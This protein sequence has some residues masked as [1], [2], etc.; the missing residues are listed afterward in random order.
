[1]R[2]RVWI[3]ALIIS[4]AGALAARADRAKQVE[5]VQQAAEVFNEV[6]GIPEKS[7]P[8]E[9][10]SRA[11]CVAIIPSMK[12]AAFGVG[13]NYGRGIVTCRNVSR[14]FGSPSMLTIGG[15][16]FGLQLGGQAIDVIM[17]VMNKKGKNF[18][19]KDKFTVGGDASASAGPVG[20]TASAETNAAMRAEILTYSRS[21]GLFA[22]ISLKG[23]VVK[24]DNDGN[25]ELYGREIPATSILDGAAPTPAEARPLVSS[26]SRY[27]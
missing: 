24:P 7:I 17:L 11:E 20:R 14:A 10:L 6:M 3:I 25:R 27:R 22:G 9:L 15:G 12:K 21:R 5:R 4:L 2:T 18:L 16:S 1:M 26:L 23:A 19:V 13:G 8:K